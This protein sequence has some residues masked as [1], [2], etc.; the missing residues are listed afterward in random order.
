MDAGFAFLFGCIGGIG[1]EVLVW[2]KSRDKIKR[3]TTPLHYWISTICMILLGG[4]VALAYTIDG[5]ELGAILSMNVG[6]TSPFLFGT[7]SKDKP[8]I[9]L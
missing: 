2:Y 4:V 7:W 6:A 3:N 5:K 9:T 1:T 8:E